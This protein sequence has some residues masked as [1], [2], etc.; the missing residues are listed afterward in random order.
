MNNMPAFQPDAMY[1]HLQKANFLV[2]QNADNGR[3]WEKVDVDDKRSQ[4]VIAEL[5]QIAQK[6]AE[7]PHDETGL[8]V[9]RITRFFERYGLVSKP[10]VGIDEAGQQEVNEIMGFDRGKTDTVA[11]HFP[12]LGFTYVVRDPSETAKDSALKEASVVHENSHANQP[13]LDILM[14]ERADDKNGISYKLLQNGFTYHENGKESGSGLE[15]AFAGMMGH[16]YMVEE[17]GLTRGFMD[18][19][20]PLR[21]EV[22][23][24]T[25]YLLPGSYLYESTTPG[26]VAWARSAHVA[27]GMQLLIAKDPEIF[28][29]LIQSR[30]GIDGHYEFA[31]RINA[32]GATGLYDMLRDT[33][34]KEMSLRKAA[35]YIIDKVY[36]G[37]Q[38]LALVAAADQ[39]TQYLN[40]LIAA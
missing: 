32:L 31:R 19:I 20:E 22:E 30:L 4:R 2:A 27:Y 25:A 16:R 7:I 21:L 12:L 10:F 40:T 5:Y 26:A 36:S 23:P 33:P 9:P 6:L 11:S 18:R 38:G 24:N 28:P 39:D 34:Y 8:N 35:R 14:H 13:F 1:E 37:D 29:A 17:L 3:P 15:E